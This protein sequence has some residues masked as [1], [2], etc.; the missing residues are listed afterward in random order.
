MSQENDLNVVIKDLIKEYIIPEFPI[1]RVKY[2][3]TYIY[4]SDDEITNNTE[5]YPHVLRSRV[6]S[7][8]MECKRCT[9]DPLSLLSEVCPHGFRKMCIHN[10]CHCIFPSTI[11]EFKIDKIVRDYKD[12]VDHL[13]IIN[14]ERIA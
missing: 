12:N 9:N 5:Y 13:T 10:S 3:H 14:I 2:V 8:L 7:R 4:E 1:Y 6:V 11:E